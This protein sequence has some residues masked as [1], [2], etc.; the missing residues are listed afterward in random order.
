MSSSPVTPTRDRNRGTFICLP[1]ESTVAGGSDHIGRVD[2]PCV[3]RLEHRSEC[4]S[5]TIMISLFIYIYIYTS[6][7][8][9]ESFYSTVAASMEDLSGDLLTDFVVSYVGGGQFRFLA[10]VNRTFYNAYLDKFPHKRTSKHASNLH[11]M[12]RLSIFIQE[13]GPIKRVKAMKVAKDM[14]IDCAA[15]HGSMEIVHLFH[16]YHANIK[17]ILETTVCAR[18]ALHGHL[19]GLRQLRHG[20]TAWDAFTC[21]SAATG[22][23]GDIL[24]YAHTHGCPWDA[25][26]CS[27]AALHGHLSVLQYA[28][29]HGCSW[30]EHTCSNAALN[31]H[32][33]TLEYAHDNGCPWNEFTCSNAALG[34]H[35]DVLVYA[36]TRNCPWNS[37]TCSNA[38]QNGHLHILKYARMMHCPWSHHTIHKALE[39]GHLEV[40]RWACRNG[41]TGRFMYPFLYE[42][43]DE[44]DDDDEFEDPRFFE[45][46]DHNEDEVVRMA[47][48]IL[49][50]IMQ[51]QNGAAAP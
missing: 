46:A 34:G 51:L 1:V 39:N 42:E 48:T 23:H 49:R 24:Q 26:T 2:I 12:E 41:C 11:S 30:S 44:E 10:A 43:E 19:E 47:R 50:S 38:A 33:A 25:W 36:F 16:R 3:H 18:A 13:V 8:Y 21:S 17:P 4:I 29:D 20:G 9:C 40:A 22:G 27:N 45:A 15:R 7:L 6:L 37:Y 5:M 31:G 35:M 28:R 14:V 32:L